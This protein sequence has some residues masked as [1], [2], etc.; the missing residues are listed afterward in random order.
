MDNALNQED[1]QESQAAVPMDTA[2]DTAAAQASSATASNGKQK[3][4]GGRGKKNYE[5]AAK[6]ISLVIHGFDKSSQDIQIAFFNGVLK[7]N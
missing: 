5:K 2:G 1:R 4:K 7:Q 3:A 6:G